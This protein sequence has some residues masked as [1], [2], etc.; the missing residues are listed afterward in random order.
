MYLFRYQAPNGGTGLGLQTDEGHRY[1]L[2]ARYDLVSVAA[3]LALPD[4]IAAVKSVSERIAD[5]P[6]LRL[7]DDVPLRAPVDFQEVWAA[8][9][10]Y[11]RSK[12]ARMEESAGGGDFYDRVYAAE[13]PELFCK[14]TGGHRVAGPGAPIRVRRDS[15][16]NVPE[17]EMTLVLS[18]AG[19]IVGVTVGNDVSS[20]DIEG[21]NPLY[22]PQAKVYDGACALGPMIRILDDE[23]DLRNLPIRLTIMR[24]GDTAFEAETTT[25]RMKRTP[26]ELAA[27]LFRELSFPEGA[28][29]M[30]GTGIVPP[31]DFSLQ[32][33][34]VVTIAIGGVGTLTNPV[35]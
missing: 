4:P 7:A 26:E 35:E 6:F 9:V 29:L 20:R 8:G 22:L 30:T 27:Y 17:P 33:G 1:N 11:E 34:D 23:L 3:W 13:R 2:A 12:V 5:R 28:F 21:E 31:D 19:K 25:A 14:A 32:S 15:A 18:S 24:G 16:W 10:T